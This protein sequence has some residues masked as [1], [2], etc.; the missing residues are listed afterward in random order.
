M[1]QPAHQPGL[2]H[3]TPIPTGPPNVLAQGS[4]IAFKNS[5][6]TVLKFLA[7]GAF[8]HVYAISNLAGEIIVLKRMFCPDQHVLEML[9]NEAETHVSCH[10][11]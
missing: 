10:L 9:V 11:H 4:L 2:L 8:A 6:L 1:N 5:N 3:K 7:E